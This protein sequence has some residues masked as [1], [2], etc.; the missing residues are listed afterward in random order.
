MDKRGFLALI[1]FGIFLLSMSIATS[2]ETK[3]TEEE[4]RECV[5]ECCNECCHL[6]NLFP[7]CILYCKEWC[8]THL[9]PKCCDYYRFEQCE[10]ERGFFETIGDGIKSGFGWVIEKAGQL[11]GFEWGGEPTLP[12]EDLYE[13]IYKASR[14]I[15]APEPEEVEVP[16]VAERKMKGDWKIVI[17]YE[18]REDKKNVAY[19]D[20]AGTRFRQTCNSKGSW[21]FSFPGKQLLAP[22]T[23][24]INYITNTV[25]ID[26]WEYNP[27]KIPWEEKPEKTPRQ[28][29]YF[30]I[31]FSKGTLA[32]KD[33]KASGTVDI[34]TC[35]PG[36]INLETKKYNPQQCSSFPRTS[37]VATKET[38]T[39]QAEEEKGFV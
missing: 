36:G 25:A 14:S 1:I 10:E 11:F 31:S 27:E 37:W 2:Q 18:E 23:M 15:I 30:S 9:T 6:L 39:E 29:V 32:D 12:E 16:A 5:P 38:R 13:M 17:G 19:L 7:G 20:C 4:C 26:D 21:D 34:K 22:A 8:S 28:S 3:K 35:V 24:K 33:S